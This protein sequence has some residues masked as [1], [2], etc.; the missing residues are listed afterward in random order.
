MEAYAE[1]DVLG[2][3]FDATHGLCQ[4]EELEISFSKC[5]AS[6]LLPRTGQLKLAP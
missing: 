2:N 5:R 4:R 1:I 3:A 6:G